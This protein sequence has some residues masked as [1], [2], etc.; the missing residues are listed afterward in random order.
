ML[1][2]AAER[3][4]RPPAVRDDRNTP[5]PARDAAE[6]RRREKAHSHGGRRATG[7]RGGPGHQPGDTP[8]RFPSPRTLSYAAAT[9]FALSLAVPAFAAE[10]QGSLEPAPQAGADK[11]APAPKGDAGSQA[12]T[13][14]GSVYPLG[15][16][17]G[18]NVLLVGGSGTAFTIGLYNFTPGLDPAMIIKGAGKTFVVNKTG[19]NGNEFYR[20]LVRG[21]VKA[22]VTVGAWHGSTV[23]NYVLKV[24]P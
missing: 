1:R 15:D 13:Y 20:V 22:R 11:A 12:V 23:G 19:V 5:R 7:R 6:T 16:T 17:D 21:T 18:Y 4:V 9:A 2:L 24:T 3:P 10:P 8:M 14:Q